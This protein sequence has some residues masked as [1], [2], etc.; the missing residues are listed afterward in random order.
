MTLNRHIKAQTKMNSI[1][2]KPWI[3][4]KKGRKI[5]SLEFLCVNILLIFYQMEG[6]GQFSQGFIYKAYPAIGSVQSMA[7]VVNVNTY[8]RKWEGMN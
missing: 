1:F 5:Q 4:K 2:I 3:S 8:L 6:A 7:V